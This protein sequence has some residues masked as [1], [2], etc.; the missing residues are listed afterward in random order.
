MFDN[1]HPHRQQALIRQ[2]IF[3]P[4]SLI[5]SKFSVLWFKMCSTNHNEV[6][7][8]PHQYYCR[9]VCKISLWSAEYAMNPCIAK[10]NWILIS[11]KIS[12]VGQAPAHLYQVNWSPTGRER[13]RSSAVTINQNGGRRTRWVQTFADCVNMAPRSPSILRT[14]RVM[15]PIDFLAWET[16]ATG[17]DIADIGKRKFRRIDRNCHGLLIV[18]AFQSR[19]L[20]IVTC[21]NES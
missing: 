12:I 8:M 3:R 14:E 15:G 6:L 17:W 2:T 7:H 4:N 10:F 21:L 18:T 16:A 13:L 11:I 9:D 1:L 19:R 5:R 20:L